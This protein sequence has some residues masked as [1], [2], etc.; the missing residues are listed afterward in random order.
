MKSSQV[1]STDTVIIGAGPAGCAAAVVLVEAGQRVVVLEQMPHAGG[2]ART[3]V[4]NGNRFDVGPHRFFTE[5]QEV[6]ALW[7]RFVG[8]DLITVDRLTR[9]F[10]E[11]KLINYPLGPLNA[12]AGLGWARSGGAV[13]AYLAS[14]A[15]R[16]VIQREPQSVEDWVTDAFGGVLY[17][18]FFKTYTE[19][20]W[21][22]PCRD[23][24]ASWAAQ[25]IKGL[26]LA[27]VILNAV[28]C[29]PKSEV[30]TLVEQFL[31]PRRGA[32]QF[33]ENVVRHIVEC[34]AKVRLNAEVCRISLDGRRV[35]T[36]TYRDVRGMETQL[37]CNAVICSAPLT[38]L[39]RFLRP[40]A[41]A[42]VRRA[43]G[44][45]RYR[46][47]IS[48]NLALKESLFPDNWLYVHSPKVRLARIANYRAFSPSMCSTPDMHP[49]TVEY[50]TFP[51][52]KISSLGDGALCE[53]AIRELAEMGFLRDECLV[54]DRFVVR[55]RQAYPL[56][57]R[58]HEQKVSEIRTFLADMKNLWPI[59]RA[60]MFKYNNQDHSAMTGLLAARN[61]LGAHYDVWSVNINAEYHE[62]GAA[63]VLAEQVM[64]PNLAAESVGRRVSG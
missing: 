13:L 14:R 32:G 3:I 5:S 1:Q 54:L 20:V 19:K 11:D 36:V 64:S 35:N 48:V 17:R 41:P 45:L 42:P 38:D 30:K 9:I 60:G 7:R 28:G 57:E 4:R 52:D 29:A 43:A 37:K 24:S 6:L 25:R 49:V 51:D 58:G 8:E 10:Y 33:C 2:L 39:V 63:P 46:E 15:K 21:G 26:S 34:G 62:S 31:Y 22:I 61:V 47:H 23:I 53:L 16:M 44:R 56:L 59:G 55:D 40:E 18:A 50:F 12:L 27:G